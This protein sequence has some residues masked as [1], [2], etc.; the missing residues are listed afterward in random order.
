MKPHWQELNQLGKMKSI[1]SRMIFSRHFPSIGS[2][3][4]GRW[5]LCD[6][7][8]GMTEV[9]GIVMTSVIFQREAKYEFNKQ[10]LKMVARGLATLLRIHLICS[11]KMP[12]IPGLQK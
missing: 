6:V 10:R 12:S 9:L 2:S 3:E 8:T 5:A 1:H 11:G 4:I 7:N